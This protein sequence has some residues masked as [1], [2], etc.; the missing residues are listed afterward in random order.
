M[1]DDCED[2]DDAPDGSFADLQE[3][4]ASAIEDFRARASE[5]MEKRA[6][7]VAV[8]SRTSAEPGQE[9]QPVVSYQPSFDTKQQPFNPDPTLLAPH[10][11]EGAGRPIPQR[12]EIENDDS[13]DWETV[14][15]LES[16]SV[17]VRT[18]D[19]EETELIEPGGTYTVECNVANLG[20]TPARSAVVELFVEHTEP[21]AG[22]D[23]SADTGGFEVFVDFQSQRQQFWAY[24]LSGTTTMA[25][26]SRLF[27]VFHQDDGEPPAESE[28][29]T[30]VS[31]PLFP[32]RVFEVESSTGGLPTDVEEFTLDIWD[33]SRLGEKTP[34]ALND[35]GIHLTRV[36]GERTP[37]TISSRTP[38]NHDL[39][40][41]V[42]VNQD[43]DGTG[44]SRR[45]GKQRVSVP[46]NGTRTVTF[47][48]EPERDRFPNA[49][50]PNAGVELPGGGRTVTAFH[51]RAYSL[52]TNEVPADW[53]RLDHTESR[54]MA[55]TEVGRQL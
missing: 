23:V 4:F 31:V 30:E 11:G 17:S 37:K 34:A 45:V 21:S 2:A 39:A 22:V 28:I 16:D 9:L 41:E 49:D 19:G 20:G 32:D 46:Q 18:P 27:A 10:Y 48:Y 50:L 6:D 33:V 38:R 35:A 12:R 44:R 7:G 13:L 40:G 5:D 53:G 15:P 55:R 51:V 24:T 29:L 1:A 3:D 52:A 8:G 25:P 42:T 36:S 43:G 47:E 14:Q 26:G 54:F